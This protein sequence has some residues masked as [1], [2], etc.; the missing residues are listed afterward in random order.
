MYAS[1]PASN[2]RPRIKAGAVLA[3]GLALIIYAPGCAKDLQPTPSPTAPVTLETPQGPTPHAGGFATPRQTLDTLQAAVHARD[4]GRVASA[5]TAAFRPQIDQW[6][7]DA[8]ADT[9]L[10]FLRQGLD[11]RPRIEEYVIVA[12]QPPHGVQ[13][14]VVTDNWPEAAAAY[15]AALR[16]YGAS[17]EL[18]HAGLPW[19]C[20][21]E[22]WL[23]TAW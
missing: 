13:W 19:R 23:L 15:D 9:V 18:F 11:A 2:R 5:F 20:E 1:I 21:Q 22:G 8:G 12:H 10:D 7:R 6:V 14:T 4:L 3:L 16:D 17:V